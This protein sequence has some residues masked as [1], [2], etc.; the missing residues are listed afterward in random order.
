MNRNVGR[1]VCAVCLF[2]SLTAQ[3]NANA[4]PVVDSLDQLAERVLRSIP[5]EEVCYAPHRCPVIVVDTLLYLTKTIVN[6]PND[7]TVRRKFDPLRIVARNSRMRTF[8]PGA[9]A[10]RSIPGA[11]TATISLMIILASDARNDVRRVEAEVLL[12]RHP[13]GAWVVCRVERARAR[14]RV[15]RVLAIDG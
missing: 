8:V 3:S 7:S 11:D 4:Q 6:A 9:R 1:A 13:F 14:W 2:A 10:G 15:R 5:W 12:P